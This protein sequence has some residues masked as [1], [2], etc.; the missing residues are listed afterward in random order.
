IHKDIQPGHFFVDVAAARA[1]LTGFGL[2]SA[3]PRE[4]ASAAHSDIIAGTLRYMAPEQTG[5]MNRSVDARSDL[6]ALGATFYEMLTGVAPFQVTDPAALM[7]AHLAQQPVAPGVR[8]PSLP[9][10]LS[11]IV[12]KL[13]AKA[14]EDRYQTAAGLELDLRRCLSD[15]ERQGSLDDFVLGTADVPRQ[16][17][18]PERLYGREREVAALRAAF[19]RVADQGRIELVLVHGPAGIGKS[20][21]VRELQRALLGAGGLFASGKFDQYTRDVPL[22]TLSQALQGLLGMVLG[23]PEPERAAWQA[24]LRKAV[25][26]H[27]H[28]IAGLLPQL[29]TL[30]GLQPE[31]PEPSSQDAQARFHQVFRR[32]LQVFARREHPLVLFLDDLQWADRATGD[33]LVQWLMAPDDAH[34]LLVGACRDVGGDAASGEASDLVARLRALGGEGAPISE[35]ALRPLDVEDIGWL[36]ADTLRTDT[37]RVA[38][39]ARRVHERT[40]GNPFF[41]GQFIT[42]LADEHLLLYDAPTA[43]WTWDIARI[44]ALAEADPGAD[45]VVALMALKLQRLPAATRGVL[46]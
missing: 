6:Y 36:V 28:F 39:L 23:R 21:M 46:Q 12:M 7:H 19:D 9:N 32:F 30:I 1:W 10:T 5:R 15:W 4:Q 27:G 40:G 16:L 26:P 17:L 34:L 35:I 13:L 25:E 29:E 22:A 8:V 41:A 20:S 38:A 18:V 11:R 42:E 45:A 24:A 14:A 31:G 33:L 2:A 37:H 3:V 44:D 43:G